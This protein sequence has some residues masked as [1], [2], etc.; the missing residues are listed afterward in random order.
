[1]ARYQLD[2]FEGKV[3]DCRYSDKVII[4]LSI[5]E[6]LAPQFSERLTEACKGQISIHWQE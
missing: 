3:L 4:T 6:S 5:P 1:V 2:S